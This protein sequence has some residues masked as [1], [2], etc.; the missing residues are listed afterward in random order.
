M[1]SYRYWERELG[2]DDFIYGQFGENFTIEGPSDDEVCIGDRYQIGTAVFE[3]TQPRVTCYRV[4]I[5]MSDPRIPALLVSHRRPE[6]LQQWPELGRFVRVA[7]TRGWRIAVLGAS[8]DRLPLYR[9][10]GLRPVKLGDEAV[11]RPASFSLEGRAV[12]KVRQSV[13]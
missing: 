5:R 8:D 11:V 6:L 13:R 1:D 3:V 9:P 10:L 2:R 4:G 7:R 12:R